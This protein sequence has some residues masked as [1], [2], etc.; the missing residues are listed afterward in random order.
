MFQ[1]D[2]IR[3]L[4]DIGEADASARLADIRALLGGRVVPARAEK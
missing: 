3:R 1:N 4:V 2:Y